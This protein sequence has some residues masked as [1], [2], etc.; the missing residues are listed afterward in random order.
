MSSFLQKLSK[1][2][3][4]RA[5]TLVVAFVVVALLSLYRWNLANR[6]VPKGTAASPGY[7]SDESDY[8]N[9][10]AMKH[11]IFKQITIDIALVFIVFMLVEVIGNSESFFDWEDFLSF[12]NFRAFRLSIIGGS[13]TSVVGYMIFYQFVQP[14]I[15]NRIPPLS[16][17]VGDKKI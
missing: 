9:I 15:V 11:D 17:L 3:W 14:Y 6:S 7:Y 12:R 4:T 8:T 13:M 2:M 5:N 10:H 16:K 1:T